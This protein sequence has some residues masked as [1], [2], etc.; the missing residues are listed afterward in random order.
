MAIET[1]V[2]KLKSRTPL[3]QNNPAETMT[4]GAD[5]GLT[6]GKKK[7]D[8]MDEAT[9][10]TYKDG[11][12][13]VHPT[14]AIRACLLAAAIGRK[15]GKRAAKGVVAGAVFPMEL[16][17]VILDGKGKPH[18]KW[19]IDKCR[20]KVGQAGVIRCR[21]RWDEWSMEVPIE[22]DTDFVSA[23]HVTDLLN[24]AGR[25]IGIGDERPDTTNRRNGVGICGR[26]TADLIS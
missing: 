4:S 2:W 14:A 6:A 3:K 23:E 13:F 12:K 16:N 15:I 1:H 5:T 18:K 25:I 9:M 24:I 17:M 19:V 11:D 10:R 7:Y 8:D 21:P 26:F 20:V 22:I